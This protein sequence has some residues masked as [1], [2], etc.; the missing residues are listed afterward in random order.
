MIELAF[1][2]VLCLV[3][4]TGLES[5]LLLNHPLERIL[6]VL[7]LA[8]GHLLLAIQLLSL[9]HLLTGGGLLLACLVLALAGGWATRLWPLPAGRL[10]WRDL[11]KR[12]RAETAGRPGHGPALG[13]L[14][15]AAGLILF[16]S[17][18]GAC[19]FPLEDSYHHEKPVYWM[20]N[21][22]I[23]PFV[24]NNPRINATSFADSALAL[25]GYLYCRSG[26]MFAVIALG[27][28]LLSLAIVFSLARKLGSSWPA[29]ACASV[30]LL[31]MSTFAVP[32][33]EV[34][35]AVYLAAVW[36]GASLLFLTDDQRSLEAPAKERFARLGCSAVC[37]LMACGVKNTS[38]FLAPF[39]LAGLALCARPLLFQKK[40]FLVLAAAGMLGLVYSGVAW[41]YVQ[42]LRWYGNPKGPP[43]MQA[44]VSRELD[45]HSAWTRVAR[46]AVLMAA[47]VLYIPVSARNAYGTLCQKAV[48]VIGGK[49]E[50]GEDDVFYNFQKEKISPRAATGLVGLIF[51]PPAL[52]VGIRR[53]RGRNGPAGQT[54]PFHRTNIA[55]LL[56][57]GFGYFA[58][59]HIFLRWQSIGLWRL[60]PAFPVIIAP[61]FGLLL[62]RFRYRLAA[63][64]LVILSSLVFLVFDA[65][66]MERRFA[67]L[68]GNRFFKKLAGVGKQHAFT[69][70]CQWTNQPPQELII[71]EDYSDRQIQQKFLEQVGHA[72]VIAFV[73]GVNSD[74]YYLFG[75]DFSNTVIALNDSR[76]PGPLLPP[77][78]NAEY[79]IF[80]E[81]YDIDADKIA[82]ASNQGYSPVFQV[83]HGKECLFLGFKK[84]ATEPSL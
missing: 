11:F 75:R 71:R 64:L 84:T 66:M 37:F 44:H 55:L 1:I 70:T 61:L 41:N 40:S 7:T 49:N 79:L 57:F 5:R 48:H 45:F 15:F 47:D 63:L 10:S 80:G 31:G 46:G 3:S 43:F 26:F 69:V 20:Q 58:L 38:I 33:L 12:C 72:S 34:G 73:G 74:T 14:A 42:N 30:L 4:A 51:L 62:G 23:E 8:A 16:Y 68:D 82:W 22:S 28:G 65:G 18:L 60:M 25:P 83:S 17:I 76:N 39:Y 52:V 54:P 77:P 78:G 81:H 27:A 50:L 13:L 56:L 19:M 24:V 53:M 21:H 35:V 36:I 9:F 32:F 2:Y 6:A 29:A 59:C 67:A